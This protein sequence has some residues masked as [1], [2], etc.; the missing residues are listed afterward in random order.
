M[1]QKGNRTRLQKVRGKE[2]GM[3]PSRAV[4]ESRKEGGEGGGEATGVVRAGG[5]QHSVVVGISGVSVT[6][7]DKYGPDGEAGDGGR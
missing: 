6:N 2:G 3:Q 5:Q 7:R 1:P 4:K